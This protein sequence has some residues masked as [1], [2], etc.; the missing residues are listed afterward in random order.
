MPP[1]HQRDPERD[2]AHW[3]SKILS[4]I[5]EVTKHGLTPKQLGRE[6]SKA[7]AKQQ[8]EEIISALKKAAELLGKEPPDFPPAAFP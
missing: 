7:F 1:D 6:L 4:F 3:W 8:I 2:R 5:K